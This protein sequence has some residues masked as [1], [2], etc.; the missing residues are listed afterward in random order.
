MR[1]PLAAVFAAALL[2]TTA[3]CGDDGGSAGSE[4]DSLDGVTV[5]GEFGEEPEV[6]TTE[7]FAAEE[8]TSAEVVV[9]D[10]DELADD[11]VVS[12]KIAVF[13]SDGTLV[14]GNYDSEAT[15]RIDLSEGQAPWLAELIGTHI[16]SRV[17]VALPVAEVIGPE[18]APQAGLDPDEPM[19][20]LVDVLEEAEAQL[21]GPEGESV[22]PPANAPKVVGDDQVVELDFSDAP[23]AAPKGFRAI[24]LVEG[25]GAEVQEGEQVTV[26]YFG[27][28]WGKGKAP[29]DSSFERGEPA[30][31]PLAEGSL[32]DGWVQGLA[33]TTVGSRVMLIIPPRLGYGAQGQ[34]PDIPGNATLVFVIDVLAAG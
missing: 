16:G 13:D 28:V 31:F 18:G 6:E 8:A 32:I 19:L 2:L 21:E 4:G 17:A 30:T 9:G 20:F 33:G 25:E 5:S 24:P 29:F 7:D 34:E 1:R 22:E 11:S 27:T 23:Q 26:N 14:Q 15:E 10:G 12:A 3:A